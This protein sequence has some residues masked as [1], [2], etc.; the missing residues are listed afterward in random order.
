MTNWK[1]AALLAVLVV[2]AVAAGTVTYLQDGGDAQARAP[3]PDGAAETPGAAAGVP[4]AATVHEDGRD[5]IPADRTEPIPIKVYASPTCGCCGNW[6]EHIEENGFDVDLEHRQ[7]MAAVKETLGLPAEYASCH[8]AV[9]NDYV[10][11]GHLPA[12]D[13]RRFL[14]EAPEARGLAVPGMPVG[15]PG[16]EVP[17]GEV[18]EYEVVVFTSEGSGEVFARHGPED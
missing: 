2:A 3:A 4:E 5:A 13:L 7:D 9:V 16:M 6:V 18:D 11:E 8:T 12:E 15:S 17:G 14:E 10:V 1:N